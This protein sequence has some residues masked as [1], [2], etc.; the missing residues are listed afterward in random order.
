MTRIDE[1]GAADSQ[2]SGEFTFELLGETPRREPEVQRGIKPGACTPRR[3]NA[4]AHRHWCLAGRK[5]F[6]RKSFSMDSAD[7]LANLRSQ[8]VGLSLM[9]SGT[10]GTMR[11]SCQDCHQ[12]YTKAATRAL[13]RLSRA[14]VLVRIS[15]FGGADVRW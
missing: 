5:R 15:L 11:W 14:Q 12:A 13:S 9:L 1:D 10:R 6:R 2:K 3:R 8:M 4:P 7:Q